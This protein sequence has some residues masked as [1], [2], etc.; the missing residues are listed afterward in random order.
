MSDNHDITPRPGGYRGDFPFPLTK[1]PKESRYLTWLRNHS[2]YMATAGFMDYFRIAGVVVR[3]I[4][5][6][7]L[8]LL[9]PLLLVSFAVAHLYRTHLRSLDVEPATVRKMLARMVLEKRPVD[10]WLASQ[11]SFDPEYEAALKAY[12]TGR[13]GAQQVEYTQEYTSDAVRDLDSFAWKLIEHKDGPSLYVWGKLS[14]ATLRTLK[15]WQD[16]QTVS[17]ELRKNLVDDLNAIIRQNA[18]WEEEWVAGLTGEMPIETKALYDEAKAARGTTKGLPDPK[19]SDKGS[20]RLNRLLLE[21]AFPLELGWKQVVAAAVKKLA[22]LA[23]AESKA[24]GNLRTLIDTTSIYGAPYF[25]EVTLRKETD[26]IRRARGDDGDP[27]GFDL[28]QLNWLLLEDAY[29]QEL[30]KNIDLIAP[31]GLQTRAKSHIAQFRAWVESPIMQDPFVWTGWVLA[32]ALFSIMISPILVVIGQVARE[33]KSREMAGG[34]ASVKRRDKFERIFGVALLL[35]VATALFE[36][37]PV[38][39]DQFHQFRA[40]PQLNWRAYLAL[41][42]SASVA[43]VSGAGKVLSILGGAK[44]KVAMLLIGLLSLLA[45]LLVITYVTEFLVYREIDIRLFDIA[46]LA[47]PIFGFGLFS[48]MGVGVS[49][50]SFKLSELAQ[51]FG[52]ALVL[53]VLGV[54]IGRWFVREFSDSVP[55]SQADTRILNYAFVLLCAFDLWVFCRLVVDINLTSIH[56][57]YRDRLAAAYLMG[58]DAKGGVTVGEDVP[59][60]EIC[61]HDA[62]STAPYHLINAALNLQG[63]KDMNIRDR[64]SDFFIFSKKFIGGNR[65]GYCRTTTMEQIH[66]SMDLAT[67]MAISAAAAS[68]NMGRSTNPATVA[69]MVLLNIRLGYWLPN[70][71]LLEEVLAGAAFQKKERVARKKTGTPPGFGFAEVFEQE[72]VEI[73]KR[74]DRVYRD[75]TQ[76]K[77]RQWKMTDGQLSTAPTTKHGLV[78]IAFSGGG[79]RSATI[80][81]GIAQALDKHGIFDHV[82]YMSTVSGGGYLGSSISALMRSRAFSD[83]T[84]KASVQTDSATGDKIVRVHGPQSETHEYRYSRFAKL[85]QRIVDGAEVE[86]GQRLVKQC[87]GEFRSEIDGTVSVR[88]GKREGQIVTVEG[89]GQRAEYCF[90]KF[91]SLAVKQG[92]SVKKGQELIERHNFLSDFFRWRVRPSALLK[93]MMMKLDETHRWVNLSDGGHLENLAVIELLRRRC[94][95]I[96]IGDGEADP[97]LA[98]NGLATLIRYARIDLGIAIDLNPDQIRRDRQSKA[99]DEGKG[100]V[101]TEHWAF[102]TITYPP[103]QDNGS[104]EEQGYLIYLKSSYSSDEDEMIKEYRHSHPDFPHESTAD[105]FFHENQFECYRALGQHIGEG[106]IAE[107]SLVG[108]LDGARKTFKAFSDE[109]ST[110]A[111]TIEKVA[112]MS[113]HEASQEKLNR[114]KQATIS[115]AGEVKLPEKE[116]QIE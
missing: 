6:N 44:R 11:L 18:I 67:A 39:V 43:A 22:K 23:G 57:L 14:E 42:G 94:K 61:C 54:C 3:G 47:P 55:N 17:D 112:Q 2:N 45:P 21:T 66:P 86:A 109:L 8:I 1:G 5:L 10:K 74:W 30:P 87:S 97:E 35:I 48:A 38:L 76:R 104:Q 13:A 75:P 89:N 102:G 29:D 103:D 16:T 101:S 106:A 98:F 64:D 4:L 9:S 56:G 79:I 32:A 52:L 83:V 62:G 51:I 105:Q 58:L 78:G 88:P 25:K 15:V 111:S 40:A 31:G 99:I 72:L 116:K 33:K 113:R 77:Q 93:E 115:V 37:L 50:R 108:A 92:D 69:F 96:I 36:T 19:P 7:F 27:K 24:M 65:T 91:D 12:G 68:P 53:L 114:W 100:N 70:P 49:K 84:G 73:Q 60:E 95:F 46:L 59:L 90:S 85:D 82:D 80:N 20:V 110:M 41:L 81:L 26:E 107:M 28:R 63:S 34:D 71:G